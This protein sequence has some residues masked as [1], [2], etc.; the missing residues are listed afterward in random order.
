VSIFVVA[1]AVGLLGLAS[2]ALPGLIRRSGSHHGLGHA[3]GGAARAGGR[4]ASFRRGQ[5]G[6]RHGWVPE[7]RKVLDLLALFGAFGNLL[8]VAL[9][10]P[11]WRAAL[12]AIL[13]ALIVEAVVLAPLWR[14][15]LRFQGRPSTPMAAL[16]LEE[17]RAVTAFRNGRGIV[18]VVR[19][20]RAVQLPARMVAEHVG[21]AVSVGDR[22]QVTDVDLARE[23]VHVALPN[24]VRGGGT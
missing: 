5:G 23:W 11:V 9:G 24:F 18:S 7:P 13:P 12:G 15:A 22:L 21:A 8:D 17:A 2:M 6:G 1:M 3:Q 16:I 14:W 20:G 19:D 4:G 10:W